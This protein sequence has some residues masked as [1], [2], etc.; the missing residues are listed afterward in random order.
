MKSSYNVNFRR[1]PRPSKFHDF[2][3]IG[4]SSDTWHDHVMS[5]GNPR[6]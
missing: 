1:I 3:G 4:G 5:Y 2:R 6:E